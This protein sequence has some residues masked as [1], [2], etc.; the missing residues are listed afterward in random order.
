M[1]LSKWPAMAMNEATALVK[2]GPR[3][4]VRHFQLAARPWFIVASAIEFE[5]GS[6][7]E[8]ESG[9]KA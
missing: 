6:K 2:N 8:D 9:W 5:I 7:R 4:H 1:S 3:T